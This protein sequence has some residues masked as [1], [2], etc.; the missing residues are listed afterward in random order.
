MRLQN[1]VLH[2][3]AQHVLEQGHQ[4]RA[5]RTSISRP[6][7]KAKGEAKDEAKDEDEDTE[8]TKYNSVGYQAPEDIA[9]EGEATGS[10]ME[11]STSTASPYPEYCGAT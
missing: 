2:L 3:Q 6:L 1:P 10:K 11:A 9:H 5:P 4:R 7:A 8:E